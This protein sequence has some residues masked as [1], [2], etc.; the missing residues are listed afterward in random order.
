MNS[1]DTN[2]WDLWTLAFWWATWTLADTYL[3]PYTP[4]SEL[5]VLVVCACALAVQ[6]LSRLY[7]KLSNRFEV[8]LANV[9]HT[10]TSASYGKQ[11]DNV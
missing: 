9:T 1:G 4:V 3:I 6:R 8:Q 2:L 7:P 5:V 10:H 11:V